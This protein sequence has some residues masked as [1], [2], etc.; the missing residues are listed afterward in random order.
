METVATTT[1]MGVRI[2]FRAA[3][4]LGLDIAGIEAKTGIERDA[5]SDPDTRIPIDRVR[6]LAEIVFEAAQDPALALHMIPRYRPFPFHFVTHIAINS[7]TIQDGFQQWARYARLEADTNRVDLR[8]EGRHVVVQYT[9]LSP[10]QADWIAEYYLSQAIINCRTFVSRDIAPVQA[11]FVHATPGHVAAYRRLFRAPVVFGQKENAL[12]FRREDMQ[13]KILS[14][15]RYLRAVLRRQAESMLSS[16]PC[17]SGL[18]PQIEAM[19]VRYLPERPLDLGVV[20][21]AMNM[22]PSTLKR[23]LRDERTTFSSLL[24]RTRQKL[25]VA[26]LDQGFSLKEISGLLGFSEPSAFQHAFKRWFG[27]S[28]GA[29]R[30]QRT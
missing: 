26:Y 21:D 18:L 30:R 5:L 17:K 23:R 12:V 20:A 2:F 13:R 4:A 1:G 15:N 27:V 10:Y 24:H 6:V 16:M 22:S 29:F 9:N 28:P 8:K 25:A 3:T 11:R 19:I 7:E 14:R